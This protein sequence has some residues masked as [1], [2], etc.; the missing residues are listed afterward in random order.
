MFTRAERR[1]RQKQS[2]TTTFLTF[3]MILVT[4]YPFSGNFKTAML[5]HETRDTANLLY[6]DSGVQFLLDS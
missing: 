2:D 4:Y 1:M 5:E 6:G 3:F